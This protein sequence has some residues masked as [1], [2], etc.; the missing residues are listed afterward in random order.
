M[1]LL[2]V[3]I[4]VSAFY[5]LLIWWLSVRYSVIKL[6]LLIGG[7]GRLVMA[8]L[9][10]LRLVE[11]PGTT[12]DAIAFERQASEWSG[13]PWSELFSTFDIG[14]SYAI[15]TVGAVFY[16]LIYTSPVMLN[17]INAA[18]SAWLIV[19][20]F[21]LA[22]RLFGEERGKAAAWIIALFPYAVLYGSVFRREVFGS[23]FLMLA[24]LSA[25][26]WA[27]RNNPVLFTLS[28]FFVLCAAVFHGAFLAA[29]VGL[30]LYAIFRFLFFFGNTDAR[31]RGNTVVSISMALVFAAGVVFYAVTA[32]VNINTIG[33]LD[34]LNVADSIEARVLH[35]V[36]DGGSSYPDVLR[37]VDPFSNPIVLPGRL[38]Y[39][40][41]SPFPWDISAPSHLLGLFATLFFIAVFI[42]IYRSRHIIL[43]TPKI[44]IVAVMV[45]SCIL[46]FG[47]SIDNIGTSIRHRTKFIYALVALCGAPVFSR[48][49]LRL[50]SRMYSQNRSVELRHS[51]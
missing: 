12:A 25:V 13:L 38:V 8:W 45:F 1:E 26:K 47:I 10:G 35:R 50:S 2:L 48:L 31:Y 42:S 44:L 14:G 29:G 41:F 27:V 3:N 18:L 32:G 39:F 43:R 34:T 49:R 5:I 11:I 36:S 16:K 19:L 7:G 21:L 51:K 9:I 46:V 20:A 33:H 40:L 22:K 17:I 6:Q 4:T 23:V 28:L 37:G 24:L 15:S 30:V